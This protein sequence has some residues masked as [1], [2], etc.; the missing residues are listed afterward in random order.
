M[1]KILFLFLL[2]PALTACEYDDTGLK[3]RLDDLDDKFTELEARVDALN[4]DVTTLEQLISG[5]RFISNV[6]T[7]EDGSYTLTLVTPAGESSTITIRNGQNGTT[8]V[9]GVKLDSDG[10]YYWT[11]NGEFILAGGKKLPVSGENGVT[12]EFK[13]DGGV[14]YVSYDK[15]ATWD[16]CG[17]ATGGDAAGIFKSVSLSEDG[18]TVFITLNDGKDTVLAFELYMQFGIAFDTTSATLRVGETLSVPFTLTGAD[19]K[20]LIETLPAEGWKA[21]VKL[22]EGGGSGTIDVTA[23]AGSSTGKVIV[24]VND[25]G[26]KTL[27]RTLTFVAGVLN[28]STS[29]REATA[30]GGPVTVDVET[31]LEYEASIPEAAKSWISL[32]ETRGEIRHET[33]T[34][35]VSPNTLSEPREAIVELVSGGTV[36]ETVLIYQLPYFDPAAFTVKVTAKESLSKLVILPLYGTVDATIDW[37]DGQTEQVVETIAT[38]A[39]M[40]SH[41]YAQ[42]GTYYVTV[43]GSAEKLNA[44]LTTKANQSDIL[45][46]LQWGTL[47]FQSLEKAF[48]GNTVLTSLP[49][50][51]EGAFADVTSA[52]SMF[53]NCTALTS[54]PAGLFSGAPELSVIESM[55]Y[56]CSSLEGVPDG[57]FA[58]NTKILDAG[59]LFS[60][61]KTLKNVPETL[62][63]DMPDLEDLGSAFKNCTSLVGVPANLFKNVPKVTGISALF[64]GCT[65]LR[66]LPENLFANQTE[67]ASVA[68]MFKGCKSL[69]SIPAGLLDAFS[70]ATNMASLFSGCTS[71]GNL[72]QDLFKNMSAVT[73][74]NYLYEGCVGMSEFPSL[75][76]CTSLKTVNAMWKDCS[77]LVNAPSDI[78][79]DSEALK[80]GTTIAYMFQNCKAL[81]TVPAD[82]FANMEGV[83]IISQAFENCTSLE[84]LPAGLFDNMTKINNVNKAFNGCINFTGESPYT[85]VGEEKIH[86]YDRSPD[87]GFTAISK[88]FTDCFKNCEKIA[89]RTLIPIAWG[90]LND[91]TKAKPTFTLSMNAVEGAEYYS[92]AVNIKGTELKS[93]RFG[94]FT[95]ERLDQFLEEMGGSYEKVCNRNCVKFTTAWLNDVN[96]ET[97]FTSS[98]STLEAGTDYVLLVS[99][100]NVH[101]TTVA[102]AEARTADF[103]AG[104][105]NYERYIGTWTV[106][107]ASSEKSKQPLT[108]SIEV[109]PY[110]VNESYTVS[111]WGIT[112]WGDDYPF[113][114]NYEAD[115]TVSI[116]TSNYQGMVGGYYVYLKYRFFNPETGQYLLWSSNDILAA[117]RY[118]ADGTV[119]IEGREFTDPNTSK[120]HTVSG[121]DYC[122][123][124]N[125]SWYEH[126]DF[127]KPGFTVSDYTVG[128]YTMTKTGS[129]VSAAPAHDLRTNLFLPDA[130]ARQAVSPQ[131]GARKTKTIGK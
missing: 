59:S 58:G 30:A 70:K 68:L 123:Y 39:A 73:T 110:R 52:A 96:S 97:G 38:K 122:L 101:G 79:P 71:L 108:F 17:P 65:A 67:A 113:T 1:K 60:G 8:P 128:P 15:G 46:V 98:S 99:G 29:S 80:T 82:L 27:M 84:S 12:P 91:G 48:A 36:I 129:S 18:K 49:E 41:T 86:L 35:L 55:F 23:P 5:K 88:N 75:K 120:T 109:K 95:K 131:T 11:L 69:E 78:F 66:T 105:A 126:A 89:D 54:L 125:G 44:N 103:P 19:E 37:G 25:G 107:S 112:T 87:N 50:P 34:F 85:M 124:Q 26:D 114:M 118:N 32:S 100:T 33:L 22:A 77:T 121:M 2:L 51:A 104:D 92:I 64:Q 10:K 20:T 115:G 102:M 56:N 13:I 130:T 76:G 21:E 4:T 31:D 116:P 81:K 9:I 74:A 83:T 24:L 28:I 47:N 63:A 93:G 16:E 7:N 94:L 3:K 119:A 53:Y 127:F 14:W 57:L 45:E 72:P 90:G 62:F 40:K 111:S 6:T 117:G 43:K 106:T 42:A 61:C